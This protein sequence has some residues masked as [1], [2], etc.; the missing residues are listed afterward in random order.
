MSTSRPAYVGSKSDRLL[1]DGLNNINYV[2]FGAML[3]DP[4]GDPNLYRPLPAVRRP[5]RRRS[6]RSTRTTTACR[7][8]S[9]GRASK[10]SYTASYTLSKA[11]GIRGGG[12]GAATQSA[13]RHPRFRLRRPR[14]RPHATCLNIGYSWLLPDV[15]NSALMNAHPRRLAVDGRVDLHQRRAAAAAGVDRRATSASPAPTPTATPIGNAGHHRL[16]PTSR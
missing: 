15:E 1:N 16:A 7:R 8:C 11:L 12:Q 2:P 10:F 9:A 6:T 4:T 13:R 3:N 5:A 14:L